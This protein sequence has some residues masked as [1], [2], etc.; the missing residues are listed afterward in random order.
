MSLESE[1][2]SYAR[3]SGEWFKMRVERGECDF[4]QQ[5]GIL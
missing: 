3:T 5:L 4:K 2:K 1:M